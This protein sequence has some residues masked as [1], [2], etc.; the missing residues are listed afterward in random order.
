MNIDELKEVA[1]NPEVVEL[2][3]GTRYLVVYN[4]LQV[5]FTQMRGMATALEAA[6]IYIQLIPSEDP[7]NTIRVLEI[8]R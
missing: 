4:V 7:V 6:G 1:A 3:P 2:K 5:T 8:K